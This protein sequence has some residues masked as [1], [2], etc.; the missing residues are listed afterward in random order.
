MARL[1]AV[2]EVCQRNSTPLSMLRMCRGQ[3]EEETARSL[4]LIFVVIVCTNTIL[5]SAPLD[6]FYA[7]GPEPG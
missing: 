1:S 3:W 4:M 5:F 6:L 7:H 2:R